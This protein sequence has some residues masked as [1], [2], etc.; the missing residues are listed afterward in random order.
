MTVSR[1]FDHRHFGAQG[2]IVSKLL[3]PWPLLGRFPAHYVYLVSAPNASKSICIWDRW[4]LC[5]SRWYWGISTTRGVECWIQLPKCPWVSSLG[6]RL[7]TW[8]CTFNLVSGSQLDTT[9][10]KIKSDRIQN[11]CCEFEVAVLLEPFVI[12]ITATRLIATG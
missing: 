5:G 9:W 8:S 7:L 11:G 6:Y 12:S 10:K 4:G 2:D 3:S 1:M